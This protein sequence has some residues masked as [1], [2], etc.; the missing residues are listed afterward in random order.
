MFHRK[1]GLLNFSF[2]KEKK[3]LLQQ[4]LCL[5]NNCLL[6]KNPQNNKKTT[7]NSEE[8]PISSLVVIHLPWRNAEA[9][10]FGIP[11]WLSASSH[12]LC[13]FIRGN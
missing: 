8:N 10:S 7:K 4:E 13:D 2:Y 12:R 1:L 9:L 3:Q 5:L 6:K 11:T